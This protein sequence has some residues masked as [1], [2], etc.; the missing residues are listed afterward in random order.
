MVGDDLE[1]DIEPAQALGLKTWWISD[2]VTNASQMMSGIVPD[3]QGNLAEFL[4]WLREVNF[5]S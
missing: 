1:N 2:A 4:N 5:S 3:K